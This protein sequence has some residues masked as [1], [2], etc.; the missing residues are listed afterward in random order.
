MVTHYP[1]EWYYLILVG[2]ALLD[3]TLLLMTIDRKRQ[4][5]MIM[6]VTLLSLVTACYSV[7]L[8]TR[9]LVCGLT[10]WLADWVPYKL[11]AGLVPTLVDWLVS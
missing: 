5:A 2:L 8:L 9:K 7:P 6:V 10:A 4:P 11:I 1:I 3:L